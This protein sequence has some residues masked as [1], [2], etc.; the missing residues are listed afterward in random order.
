MGSKTKLS[1]FFYRKILLPLVFTSRLGR[2]IALGH[3][4]K[5]S[6]VE[7]IYK[8]RPSGYRRIG[9]L[10]DKI[11][12]L[13]PAA[14][15][16]REKTQRI[17]EIL[18]AEIVKN[19]QTNKSTRIVDL[20]SGSAS[21]LLNLLKST[22]GKRVEALCFDIDKRT[23]NRA[24]RISKG[25]SIDYRFGNVARLTHY[26]RLS[27]KIGWKPNIV[28]VSTCY[29]FMDDAK[30]RSSI[31]E[32]YQ[33]LE[34]GGMLFI[35]SQYDNPSKK[36]IKILTIGNHNVH[37]FYRK[38]FTIKKWMIE[39]GFKDIKTHLERWGMYVFYTGRKTGKEVLNKD[40]APIFQKAI[41]Y[42]RA[43]EQRAANTY[44]YM[45]GFIPL[46]DGKALRG[47]EKVIMM[48]TNDYLG[49]RMRPEVL[50]AAT[51]ALRKY[52]S[53]TASS[54]IL[55][56]N[57]DIHEDLQAK[58]AEFLDV[59]DVLLFSSGYAANLGVVSS[60]LEKD[61]VALID[62][63]VHA[64]LLDGCKLSAG[65]TRFF[66]HNNIGELEKL[67]QEDIDTS[68]R[69]IICDSVYS[70]DGDMAPLPG[71]CSLAEKYN[72][73]VI[74]DDG[75]ATGVLGKNGGGSLEYFNIATNHCVITGS[76]GK[77]LASEGGFAAGSHAI[78]D[79]LR[80][81]ARSLLFTT[82][83]C[84][85]NV[86]AALAALRIIQEEPWLIERLWSNTLMLRTGLS[87]MG[88]DTGKSCSP[89]IPVIIGDE[90]KVYKLVL[91]L[92]E[93]G[94]IVDG[95][96]PPAVKKNLS[97]VRIRVTAAHGEED[98]DTTLKEFKKIGGKIGAI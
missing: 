38:P 68:N 58:L 30:V 77:A 8:N 1:S 41:L 40:S 9:H 89:I 85:A 27:R 60:L 21:Y 82:A 34:P 14:R 62:R 84:P 4:G 10:V 81:T 44:Q 47:D 32:I 19:L 71:I 65:K 53:S 35:I 20:G 33:N 94:I 17:H 93:S 55:T 48:A 22:D 50:E 97:R 45:R 56:G 51:R 54:R 79:Y 7:Y 64:S 18:H 46:R 39:A 88:Y 12:L 95:V 69:L 43:S 52:G 24:R 66:I 5:G 72:S 70:M 74:I 63:N 92:E 59:E 67:L 90:S 37:V 57:L 16:T 23:L 6:F 98:L 2:M 78:I 15:A 87:D 75:H 36:L 13:L 86:A 91:A 76:L 61:D 29:E 28:V 83:L 96:G 26:I 25:S 80:H 3:L 73:G 11:L 42:R 31:D 49:L